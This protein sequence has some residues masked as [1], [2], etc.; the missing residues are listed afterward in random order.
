MKLFLICIILFLRGNV[1]SSDVSE[2]ESL[3][4]VVKVSFPLS[5]YFD[6]NDRWCTI[7]RC[8]KIT[9]KCRIWILAFSTNFVLLKLTCLVTLFDRQ[10]Q[11]F[12]NSPKW[13]IFNWTFVHSKCKRSWLR[14][15]YWMRLFLWFSNTVRLLRRPWKWEKWAVRWRRA[16][17]LCTIVS[18]YCFIKLY[19]LRRCTKRFFFLPL[20]PAVCR[21]DLPPRPRPGGASERS[22]AG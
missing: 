8:L 7:A 20:Q 13:T 18:A 14:S 17:Y 9:Q 11:V 4:A 3:K 2:I 21:S 1:G 16:W 15:H 5:I 12:K 19:E 22:K 6:E 10:L